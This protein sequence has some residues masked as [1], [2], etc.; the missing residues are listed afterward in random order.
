MS[1]RLEHS[2]HSLSYDT[3]FQLGD[4]YVSPL[5]FR[6]I[7]F[8]EEPCILAMFLIHERKLNESNVS[9]VYSENPS[10]KKN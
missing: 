1:Y 8:K 7:V 10:V 2:S 9:R 5:L 6:H 3:A 4:F